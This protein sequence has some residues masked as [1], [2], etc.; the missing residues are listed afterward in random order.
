MT[1]APDLHTDAEP[2]EATMVWSPRELAA[3][4]ARLTARGPQPAVE[5]HERIG[6]GGRC[7][8]HRGTMPTLQGT[9]DV[10]VKRLRR[11]AVDDPDARARLR[12]EA[13]FLAAVRHTGVVRSFG[14]REV[15]GQVA[16]VLEYLPGFDLSEVM[17]GGQVPPRAACQIAL[18]IAEA[19]AALHGT[20]EAG[21]RARF[22]VVHRDLKPANVRVTPAGRVCL[23]DLGIGWSA[24]GTREA[25][26]GGYVLGTPQYLA[27]ERAAGLSGP[28]ADIWAL[29]VLLAELV[30]GRR[31]RHGLG[32]IDEMVAVLEA[33]HP[34]LGGLGTC[35]LDPDPGAR[36]TA[37]A[38][39]R[40]LRRVARHLDG[41]SL[42]DWLGR[43]PA[44]TDADVT[45]MEPVAPLPPPAPRI[46]RRT[47]AM[48][49][50]GGV[51]VALFLGVACLAAL[52]AA[53]VVLA[54]VDN[55]APHV[56]AQR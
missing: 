39:V 9:V 51:L 29:G 35:T 32:S 5:L 42:V 2:P 41:P 18:Q 37:A 49:A 3:F 13:R 28:G 12:D 4:R 25:M 23:I 55:P 27:P 53:P 38:M 50:V 34:V 15:G 14:L 11:D 19:L 22:P 21:P 20:A 26:S 6:R 44:D 10:A 7:V 8:V 48:V 46:P 1:D 30:S 16:L 56:L 17:R 33:V 54:G 47:P 40:V 52:A 43:P 36:P 45:E 24:R 31:F